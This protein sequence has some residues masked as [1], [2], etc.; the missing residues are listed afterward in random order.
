MKQHIYSSLGTLKRGKTIRIAERING[1]F[2]QALD[3]EKK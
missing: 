2:K 1:I 3:I